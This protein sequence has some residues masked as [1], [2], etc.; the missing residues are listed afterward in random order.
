MPCTCRAV[1]TPG[2]G[3][4][5]DVEGRLLVRV[6]AIAQR[7]AQHAG[8]GEARR[9]VLLFLLAAN[10]PRD[11]RVIGCG[12]GKAAAARRRRVASVVPPCASISACISA[13]CAGSVSTATPA[14]F[15]AALRIIAG[16]PMS[17]FSMQSSKAAPF[18]TVASKG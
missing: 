6:L 5:V 14:W 2:R 7:L 17:M 13:K 12:A 4:A 1:A 11:R 15:F 18:A 8:Q 10:Q 9:E 3:G 16:P